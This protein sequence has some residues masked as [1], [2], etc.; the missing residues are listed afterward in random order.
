MKNYNIF[1]FKWQFIKF[2][3]LK[4]Y[5]AHLKSIISQLNFSLSCFWSLTSF[6]AWEQAL[7]RWFEIFTVDVQAEFANAEERN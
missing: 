4:N 7:P 1:F 5:D 2:F 3:C 6:Q